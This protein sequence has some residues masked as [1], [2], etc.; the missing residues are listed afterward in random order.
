V[1]GTLA[2][3]TKALVRLA[4]GPGQRRNYC[5]GLT[6]IKIRILNSFQI[7]TEFELAKSMPS[8][9]GKF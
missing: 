2:R 5:V 4:C 7:C 1:E 8:Q 3:G 9:L 6:Q